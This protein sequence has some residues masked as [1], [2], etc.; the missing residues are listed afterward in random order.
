MTA[1]RL[2]RWRPRS[3]SGMPGFLA[4]PERKGQ[5]ARRRKRRT[6]IPGCRII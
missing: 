1:F 2:D 6:L 4:G 3:C 5:P